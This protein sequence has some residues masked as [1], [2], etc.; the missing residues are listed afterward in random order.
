MRNKAATSVGWS[1]GSFFSA[2]LLLFS[3]AAV[4]ADTGNVPEPFRGQATAESVDITY[5]D[6]SY[7]LRAT[8]FDAGMSDRR[9]APSP[10]PQPG[11]LIVKVNTSSTRLEGNRLHFP[12]FEGKNLEA[13]SV[14]RRELEALP[15]AVPMAEWTRNQQPAYWLNLYNVTVVEQLAKRYPEQEIR[16]VMAK[17]R[18][19]KLLNVAGVRLSLDDIHHDILVEKWQDP[20]VV[21]GLWQG[22]VG[23]PNILR[24][25][26]TSAN[27][28]D[29]LKQNA[30]EFI[31]SNR[32]A[33][34]R[35]NALR[36]S[37]YYEDN[38]ALF[39]GGERELRAHLAKYADLYYAGRIRGAD[40]I[41]MTTSDY[42][43]ADLF[44]GVPRDVNPNA[45]NTAALQT[46]GSGPEWSNFAASAGGK[47]W[48]RVPPHVMEYVMD[49]RR[50]KSKRGG[51]VSVEEYADRPAEE[52][53]EE[54]QK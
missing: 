40:E 3:P 20:L 29:L 38:I 28:Y 2:L 4:L 42:Y 50:K 24:E 41:N 8:V 10:A 12:A 5:D 19:K 11:R 23:G 54:G 37:T 30:V 21:Y 51:S 52:T 1:I 22:Y 26:F 34:M 27:V 18:D 14:L 43:I 31:N 47:G 7:I 33:R 35:G 13:V 44:E 45:T 6:W 53:P 15:G 36:I 17:I 32:G 16:R 49:I 46:A 9:S 25:A 39:P 48:G